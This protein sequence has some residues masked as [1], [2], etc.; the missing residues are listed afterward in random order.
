MAI[1]I[2]NFTQ[3]PEV[4]CQLTA[5]KHKAQFSTRSPTIP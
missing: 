5:T 3:L 2:Q 1:L 4:I